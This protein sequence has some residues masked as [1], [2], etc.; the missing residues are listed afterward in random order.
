MAPVRGLIPVVQVGGVGID[1]SF[2]IIF[3]VLII[4]WQLFS[5]ASPITEACEGRWLRSALM[6][7]SSLL[8]NV[9]FDTVKK[10]YDPEQV[11][12]YLHLLAEK[13]GQLQGWPGTPSSRPRWRRLGWPRPSGPRP[14]PGRR[15]PGATRPDPGEDRRRP[16]AAAPGD[17]RRAAPRSSRRC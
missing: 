6:S 7:E 8:A 5:A 4:V 17:V 10:G 14:P 15:R 11:D 1:L 2:M 13:V 12:N 3:T 16:V 9:E